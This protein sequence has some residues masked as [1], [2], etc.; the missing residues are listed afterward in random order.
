MFAVTFSSL[1]LFTIE[2]AYKWTQTA[3]AS[4]SSVEMHLLSYG[5][6]MTVRTDR[7]GYHAGDLVYIDGRLTYYDWP[8]TGVGVSIGVKS[9]SSNTICYMHSVITDEDGQY[10]DNFTLSTYAEQGEYMVYASALQCANQTSFQVVSNVYNTIYIRMSGEV[11]PAYAPISRDGDIYTL[12]QNIT[13]NSTNGIV[14]ERNN[15][16]LD[17]A[18]F[19]LDGKMLSDSNGIYLTSICNVTIR[20]MSI[21]SF[22]DGVCEDNCFNGHVEEMNLYSNY[23]GIHF[24]SSDSN[25]ISG[26]NIT[27]NTIAGILLEHSSSNNISKNGQ[28]NSITFNGVGGIK[29]Q[30][31]S[32]NNSIIDNYLAS[33]SFWAIYVD[34]SRYN[35]IFYNRFSNNAAYSDSPSN[36]WDN[37][38]PAGGNYWSGYSGADHFRGPY[39]NETGS[40]G[41]G[42]SPHTISSGNVDRYPFIQ[43]RM[44]TAV[45]MSPDLIQKT[46]SD[47]GTYFNVSMTIEDVRDLFG[48][49]TNITW[50]STLITFHTCYYTYTLDAMWGSGNWQLIKS[51]SGTGWYKTVA[52]STMSSFTQYPGTQ[53]LFIV[54]FQ[55]KNPYIPGVHETPI[56]FYTHKLSDSQFKSIQHSTM[57]AQYEIANNAYYSLTISTF[58]SGSVS[59]NA[60]GPYRSGDAIQLTAVPAINWSFRYWTGNLTGSANPATLL[61]N[62]NLSVTANFALPTLYVDPSLVNKSYQDVGE[63]FN[64][65]VKIEGITDLFGFDLN[66][67]W[68]S[69]LMTFAYSH[70]DDS[71]DVLWGAGKWYTI[72][73]EA[74]SGWYKLVAMSTEDSFNTTGKQTLCILGFRVENPHTNMSQQAPIHFYTH[75]LSNSQYSGIAHTTEDGTYVYKA[76]AI[77]IDPLLKIVTSTPFTV[78][79]NVSNIIN[80]TCWQFTLFYQTSVVSCYNVTEGPFLKTGGTT[81]FSIHTINNAYNSTHGYV[82]AYCTLL[83]LTNSTKGSGIIATVFFNATSW[84][85][86]PLHLANIILGDEKIPAHPILHS[87]SDGTL[88]VRVSGVHDLALI[89]FT[90]RKDGCTPMPSICKG[91]TAN[92]SITVLNRGG[93]T[94]SFTVTAYANN[95]LMIGSQN[96]ADLISGDQTIVTIIWNTTS[97]ILANYTLSAYVTPVPGEINLVDNNFT[98]PGV[99]AVAI[100]GDINVDGKVDVKDVYKVALA[101][102]TSVEGPNPSGRTYNPNCDINDD[103]MIDVKDYYVPCKHYGE[104]AP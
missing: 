22:R 2:P 8:Q 5:W 18:G 71:F 102:G 25:T 45:K 70:Y 49:D 86:T 50:D 67:T 13:A 36:S 51:E 28:A 76:T 3:E 35:S 47:I 17:G 66:I 14:I 54:E 43:P 4:A 59:L 62:S 9:L 48:F 85:N 89:D 88:Q 79:V 92:L 94:E 58:G 77:A 32:N 103:G 39:Q 53:A 74:G 34:G 72:R 55:V 26:N 19:T 73:D 60:T 44:E 100:V 69:T 38:Y 91:Y 83:G 93:A 15:T 82:E 24:Q 64:V 11:E 1:V 90:T 33:N 98:K 46:D 40:D 87:V 104:T 6:S 31:F 12:T 84:G 29:L 30:F 52:L 56:H 97:Y 63:Y 23:Y 27:G 7:S 101:Y 10:K 80:F 95:T 21:K 75:K 65:S 37:G 68:D 42:D 96:V 61:M 78:N 20:N 57:D 99:F 41:I 16:I 81:A